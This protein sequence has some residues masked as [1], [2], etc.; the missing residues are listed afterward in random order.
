M[1]DK[2]CCESFKDFIP[3]F[4]WMLITL[5][6]IY[7]MPHIVVNDDYKLRVNHCPSCGA[8]VRYIELTE[9]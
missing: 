6:K 1:K 8:E 3:L 5:E 7:I 9:I 2:H 4:D